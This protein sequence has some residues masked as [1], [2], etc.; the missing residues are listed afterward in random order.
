MVFPF[1][2]PQKTQT[3]P[4]TKVVAV[5]A[6]LVARSCRDC[7]GR[8]ILRLFVAVIESPTHPPLVR[9]LP[10]NQIVGG[11]S[12]AP[13]NRPTPISSPTDPRNDFFVQKSRCAHFLSAPCAFTAT[14]GTLAT[15]QTTAGRRPFQGYQGN[16]PH[17]PTHGRASQ[18]AAI[19]HSG[20]L[21]VRGR[22][23][24]RSAGPGLSGVRR[25]IAGFAVEDLTKFQADD[26]EARWN[27]VRVKIIGP[28]FRPR[29]SG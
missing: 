14:R 7:S 28:L 9:R 2:F 13:S 18:R 12:C 22:L 10:I 24:T 15:P 3:F 27:G 21:I 11:A 19:E 29:K 25:P 6:V 26:F 1:S 16:G 5:R 23:G 4:A 17:D 8:Q 20:M